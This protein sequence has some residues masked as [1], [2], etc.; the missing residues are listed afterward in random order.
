ME[1]LSKYFPKTWISRSFAALPPSLQNESY[2]TVKN[3]MVGIYLI[4]HYRCIILLHLFNYFKMDRKTIELAAEC[5]RI[6]DTL[7]KVKWI[8]PVD[9]LVKQLYTEC[10]IHLQQ[11]FDQ[12]LQSSQ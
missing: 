11:H 12:I 4:I 7:P 2:E 10:K 1:W 8:M 6:E 5:Q 9:S 3:S